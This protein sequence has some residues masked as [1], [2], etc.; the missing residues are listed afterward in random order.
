[1]Y[2]SRKEMNG[3]PHS[4]QTKDYSNPK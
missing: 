2:E 4:S 3:R 1:M